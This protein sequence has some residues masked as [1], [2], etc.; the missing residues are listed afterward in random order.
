M[1]EKVNISK[2][3]YCQFLIAAHQ[4]YSVVELAKLFNNR[5]SHDSYTR[6][7]NTVKLKPHIIWEYAQQLVEK[8][9]GYLIVDDSVLDKWYGPEIDCACR[10]YSGKHH[11]VVN[12][13][14]VVNLIWNQDKEH[15]P[16]DFRIFDKPRDG[17]KKTD[18]CHD[19]L[20]TA[21]KRGF[22]NITVLMD[23]GYNDLPTL[24][25]IRTYDWKF[26]CGIESDRIVSLKPHAKS[27]VART[28]TLNGIQCHLKGY[29]FV[30]IIKIVRLKNDIDY[31][32]TNNLSLSGLAIR[33]ANDHRWKVEETH[34]GEKQTT[35]VENCQF[36]N[37]RAQRNHIF[38]STLAFLAA[39]KHRL[40]HGTSWYESK[41]RVIFDALR[42]YM[43]KPFVKLPG[44]ATAI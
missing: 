34:R 13:I 28:A 38:C 31:V 22:K 35:G 19:M 37:N 20:D 16:V 40:E 39:E 8:D 25:R 5:P 32:A 14:G 30:K 42:D 24:K 36:R 29:G 23:C 33:Q 12:G 10:Q 2:E 41:H 26:V 21:F 11:R 44:N 7:L 17:K 18:H 15:I 1:N 3:L 27:S 9:K 43:K 6:W 4:R